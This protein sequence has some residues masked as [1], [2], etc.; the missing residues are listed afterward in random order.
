L[1]IDLEVVYAVLES[2]KVFFRFKPKKLSLV[3]LFGGPDKMLRDAGNF[4]DLKINGI[5]AHISLFRKRSTN[6]WEKRFL[7]GSKLDFSFLFVVV[8]FCFCISMDSD[9][10]LAKKLCKE[11]N[12]TVNK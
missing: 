7:C 3:I 1:S 12:L 8:I 10:V 11:N 5:L 6:F 2:G 9:R 4:K